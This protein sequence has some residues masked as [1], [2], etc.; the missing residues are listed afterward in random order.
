GG[1]LLAGFQAFGDD[2]LHWH[3]PSSSLG[4]SDAPSPSLPKAL[5]GPGADIPGLA[6]LGTRPSAWSC[7]GCSDTAS[8]AGTCA[9]IS[10]HSA[11]TPTTGSTRQPHTANSRR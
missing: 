1:M 3:R 10:M 5:D 6:Y 4:D 11:P 2:V 9:A 7:R 8:A